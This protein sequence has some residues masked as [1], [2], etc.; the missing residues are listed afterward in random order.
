LAK[1]ADF[2]LAQLEIDDK[3]S[4][5]RGTPTYMAPEMLKGA[6]VTSAADFWSMGLVFYYLA[7]GKRYFTSL[8]NIENFISTGLEI[9]KGSKIFFALMNSKN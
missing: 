5:L 1:L 9:G 8:E 4:A 3:E 7:A 6:K 2:G